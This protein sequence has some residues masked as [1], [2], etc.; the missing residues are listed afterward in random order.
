MAAASAPA[1]DGMARIG[2]KE[3]A[4]ALGWARTTLDRRL[5]SDAK[6][7]VESRGDQ[8]GGWAFDLAKVRRYLN[9]EAPAPVASVKPAKKPPVIDRAQL[10]DAVALPPPSAAR[11]VSQPRRSA[12]HQGEATARQRKD[13]ADAALRENK[14]KI[15][16]GDL[17]EKSQL[18]QDLAD[19]FAA[20]GNDLDALPEQI[21]NLLGL[22]DEMPRIRE[23]LDKARTRMVANAAPLL[24]D[25]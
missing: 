10:R 13:A 25:D 17:V 18:R 6:F 19:V 1:R 24:T 20:L 21:A 12:H 11:T 15:E 3:L 23:L 22:P 8:A 9:G 16:N 4:L 2:K 5:A 14:L 7:P